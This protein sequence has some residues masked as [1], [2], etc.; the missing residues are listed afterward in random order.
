MRVEY[1]LCDRCNKEIKKRWIDNLGIIFNPYWWLF[2][3]H[4][5]EIL[6]C[7]DCKK[8]FKIWMKGGLKNDR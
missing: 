6:L 3:D 5:D 1:Y 8:E 2:P 7:K 4:F